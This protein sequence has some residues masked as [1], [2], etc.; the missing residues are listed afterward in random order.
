MIKSRQTMGQIILPHRIFVMLLC[1]CFVFLSCAS[2]D[3]HN[4]ACST[5]S[6]LNIY[7]FVMDSQIKNPNE[8]THETSYDLEQLDLGKSV[9]CIPIQGTGIRNINLYFEFDGTIEI[10]C[11]ERDVELSVGKHARLWDYPSFDD[12]TF[13]YDSATINDYGYISV[14]PA[15]SGRG[16][17][18]DPE[19]RIICLNPDVDLITGYPDRE[20]Y[21]TVNAYRN[22]K[23]DSPVI[24]AKLKF[25][26]L[27][28]TSFMSE[29]QLPDE[30]HS[31]FYSIELIS[32][33]MSETYA[34]ELAS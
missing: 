19:G 11:P 7:T 33:E 14:Y 29:H 23:M 13:S 3:E 16:Y 27:E 24:T 9:L 28:D 10:L 20:Y 15:G 26:Q 32:Y 18:G 2:E 25:V 5:V 6:P 31:R 21:L 1:V 22:G 30:S 4:E 17:V 34:M 12:R 8:W